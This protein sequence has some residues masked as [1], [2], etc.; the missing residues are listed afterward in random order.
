MI[1]CANDN[2]ISSELFRNVD[3]LADG[4]LPSS[5]SSGSKYKTCRSWC[6]LFMKYSV[7][8]ILYL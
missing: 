4:A 5:L 7:F 2:G 8:V 3:E 1:M 6:Y